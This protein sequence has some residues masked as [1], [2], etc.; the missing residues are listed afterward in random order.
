MARTDE[1]VEREQL[2]APSVLLTKLHPPALRS[3][4]VARGRLLERL[5]ADRGIR[6]IVVAAPAGS[7]KTTLLGTWRELEAERRSIAWLSVDDGDNDPVVFWSHVVEALRRVCPTLE[8]PRRPEVVGAARIMDDVLPDLVNRLTEEGDVTLVLDDFHRL[9]AGT[10]RDSVAWLAQHAPSSF[11]LVVL[12]RSDP[13]LPLATLRA[14]GQLLELH[15]DELGFSADEADLLLN[16]RL[17]LG[18]ARGDVEELVARTE[19]WPAGLY[20]AA[21]SLRAAEDRHAFVNRF[22]GANRHVVAF[23]VDEVLEAHDVALQTLML[24]CSVLERLCG[25]LCDALLERDDSAE[26]L[27]EL[28]H[29]NLFLVPLDE[30]GEWYRFHHLFRQL[31]RVQLEAREPDLAPT[32]HRRAYAWHRDNGSIDAAIEHALEAGAFVE[33]REL[34]TS[35]WFYYTQVGRHATVVAW[36]ERFPLPIRRQDAGLLLVEAWVLMLDGQRDAAAG[37]IEAVEELRPLDEGPLPD[38]FSSLEASLATLQGMITWGDLHAA[39]ASARRAAELEG[40]TAPSRALICV[41]GGWCLFF[42]GEFEE[43]DRWLAE[44]ADP[45]LELEQWRVAVS[46]LVGRSLIADALGRR[47]EQALFASEAAALERERGIAG[48]DHELP[49]ALGAVLESRGE[50]EDALSSFERAV[51]VLRDDGQPPSLALALTRQAGVL[52]ALRRDDAAQAVVEEARRVV[53]SCPD[54]GALTSWLADVERPRRARRRRQ[55]AELSER[56]LTVLRA[57]SGSLSER[58]IAREFYLSHSTIHTQ[59]RSIYRKLGVS[60]RE[61]AVLRARELG[62]LRGFSPR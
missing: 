38:G 31:L 54:P 5:R 25:P 13:A 60:S 39:A 36:L 48:V 15:A 17:D 58:E 6:L 45:A 42:L 34:I 16:D 37:S 40:P 46:A 51:A 10:S 2:R 47:D 35:R 21:L 55:S 14:H 61:D 20:L 32:L 19:G 26:Q 11:Q 3:Q 22:G 44:A 57:L 29:T 33:A 62:L 30:R 9:R 7:G 43:A 27:T 59:A 23:L 12:T 56:E 41:A 52:R 50:L 8:T 18:L 49:I 1:S 4:T 28:A 24:H 53:A